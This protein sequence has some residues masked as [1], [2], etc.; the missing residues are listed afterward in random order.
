MTVHYYV[1]TPGTLERGA[2]TCLGTEGTLLRR[3]LSL[4][5]RPSPLAAAHNPKDLA[6]AAFTIVQQLAAHVNGKI[7]HSSVY[8]NGPLDNCVFNC[9]WRL[10]LHNNNNML[11]TNGLEL[12]NPLYYNNT[13]ARE[14]IPVHYPEQ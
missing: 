14:F 9:N 11:R 12:G 4:A 8:V 3:L 13:I 5:T 2:T 10:S 7:S 6:A 1:F